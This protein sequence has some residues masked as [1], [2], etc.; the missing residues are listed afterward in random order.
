MAPWESEVALSQVHDRH[1]LFLG[2][3]KTPKSSLVKTW[4]GESSTDTFGI[5]SLRGRTV[6]FERISRF[7]Q[8]VKVTSVIRYHV[9]TRE[10]GGS[11]A[12][13][14]IPKRISRNHVDFTFGP[15]YVGGP[16]S[17][18]ISSRIGEFNLGARK[19]YNQSLSRN[20]EGCDGL[21]TYRR[22]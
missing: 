5:S 3:R 4:R 19:C 8:F 10:D 12:D 14:E 1:E 21:N 16:W 11:R 9:L 13:L 20:H 2:R 18:G 22:F 15:T 6:N 17:E 7:V